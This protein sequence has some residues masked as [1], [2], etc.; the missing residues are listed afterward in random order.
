MVSPARFTRTSRIV[1]VGVAATL[2]SSCGSPASSAPATGHALTAAGPPA[3]G[4][5][6]V[7]NAKV[8]SVW[9]FAFPLF[10]NNSKTTV[11]IT[12]VRLDS[13]P[14]GAKV[15]GY[16]VY[17][18]KDTNGYIL[19]SM[20]GDKNVPGS[21]DMTKMPNYAGKPIVIRGHQDS[22]DYYAMV[23]VKIVGHIEKHLSGC[24]V[25]Y[26]Q[27]NSKYTQKVHCEYALDMK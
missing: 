17:S 11:R 4:V 1:L 5:L 20:E 8:G 16:P 6:G 27:G 22:G 24:R 2:L 3:S 15:E 13:I 21:R 23:K 14:S 12:S 9:R 7:P 10:S 26:T 18:M 25:N 19:D